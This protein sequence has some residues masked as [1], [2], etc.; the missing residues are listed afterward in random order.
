MNGILTCQ[1]SY[2]LPRSTKCTTCAALQV[3][4]P[5]GQTPHNSYPFAM[6]D[7]NEF[8]WD[9]EINQNGLYLS[10]WNCSGVSKG[11]HGV[12]RVCL[13]LLDDTKLRGILGRIENGTAPST[14][15]QY[16]SWGVL[17]NNLLQLRKCLESKELLLFNNY[18]KLGRRT[19][20]IDDHKRLM[21]I[22]SSGDVMC[23]S[24]VMRAGLKRN[25]SI[26]AIVELFKKA[27]DKLYTAKSFTEQ[28]M[29][30]GLLFL[31]LGGAR[32]AGIAHQALGLP[33]VRTLQYAHPKQSLLVS[34]HLPTTLELQEN[35]SV[36]LN[37]GLFNKESSTVADA[38]SKTVRACPRP[39][40]YVT[41]GYL[42]SSN[43]SMRGHS[44]GM[45]PC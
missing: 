16:W 27:A 18:V 2:K 39:G 12:C 43:I 34:S 1:S 3:E 8:R 25:M 30:L 44:R 31:H 23:A 41:S 6:H 10:M 7:A 15:H 26:H 38:L 24:V 33:A 21:M 22:I 32:L 4:F 28:E 35:I 45:G 17:Q 42:R 5:P 9:I 40:V 37:A 11:A 36:S 14:P 29:G 13:S 20:I 19:H